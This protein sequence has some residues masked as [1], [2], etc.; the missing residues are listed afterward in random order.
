MPI[1]AGVMYFHKDTRKRSILL[2]QHIV[3][4]YQR[5]YSDELWWGDQLVLRDIMQHNLLPR[6]KYSQWSSHYKGFN[7]LFLPG[8]FHNHE[9]AP[10]RAPM[11]RI[12]ILH[13]KGSQ[14][15]KLS[16]Y[17]NLIKQGKKLPVIESAAN[18]LDSQFKRSSIYLRQRGIDPSSR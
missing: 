6:E 17:W 14:K 10:L 2:M 15:E 8:I 18:Y 3:D 12:F 5:R 11:S 9:S 16:E 1:N 4:L 13:F 7:L